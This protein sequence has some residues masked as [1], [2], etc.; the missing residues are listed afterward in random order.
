MYICHITYTYKTYTYIYIYIYICIER[1]RERI[2]RHMYPCAHNSR[3]ESS[4]SRAS[5][6]SAGRNAQNYY[7]PRTELSSPRHLL[8]MCIY[9]YIYIYICICT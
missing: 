2:Y 5:L 3:S 9:I 6:G 7:R 4:P 1:E 8:N